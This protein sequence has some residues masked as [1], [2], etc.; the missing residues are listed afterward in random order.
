MAVW[1]DQLVPTL[2]LMMLNMLVVLSA[3]VLLPG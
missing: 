1:P 2:L 3:A